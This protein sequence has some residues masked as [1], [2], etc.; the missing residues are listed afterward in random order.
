LPKTVLDRV[1]IASVSACCT[2]DNVALWPE[3]K[4]LDPRQSFT[5]ATTARYTPIRTVSGVINVALINRIT[6]SK[7]NTSYGVLALALTVFAGC[8][9]LDTLPDGN[10]T[11]SK[12]K[13]E[14]A[15]LDP[16]KAEASVNAVFSQFSVYMPN[17]DA[18]GASRHNDFGFPALM[19]FWD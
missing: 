1:G 5:S 12:Q 10:T 16:K 8:E 15:K 9:D 3:R 19:M 17:E 2:A 6:H 13:E 7:T 4:G 14:V 18:L 11:T